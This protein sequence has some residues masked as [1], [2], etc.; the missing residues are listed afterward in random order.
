LGAVPEREVLEPE[1]R[2]KGREV[3]KLLR[4]GALSRGMEKPAA[5]GIAVNQRGGES[6]VKKV[7]L[8]IANAL[9]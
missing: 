3:V 8:L 1:N 7:W 4:N 6:Y 2:R 9:T 5:E